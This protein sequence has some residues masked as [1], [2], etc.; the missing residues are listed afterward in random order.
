MISGDPK[1]RTLDPSSFAQQAVTFVCLDYT[2]VSSKYNELP[3]KQCPSGIRSQINFPSCWDGKNIDSPDHKSH[4]AFL[5]TGPDN[6]TCNDPM[7]PITIPR[8]FLE[9]YWNTGDFEDFRDEAMAPNQPFVFSNGDPTGY[10]FHADF[11]NGWEPSV[12]KK[13][14]DECH[15][16][17]YGDPSCCADQHIFT[18]NHTTKCYITNTVDETTT[19]TLA[20]LP[21]NNPVQ[22]KCYEDYTDLGTPGLLSPVYVYNGTVPPGT[23]TVSVAAKTSSVIQT[24]QGTCIRGPLS[25]KGVDLVFPNLMLGTVVGCCAVLWLWL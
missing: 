3:A 9:V 12:L 16:N 14:L 21:G 19:G 10:G 11:I 15:C 8:L 1:L 24:A 7:F 5:S 2:G 20:T 22:A 23:G 13:A 4:V 6:G 17:Q 18:L 25:S